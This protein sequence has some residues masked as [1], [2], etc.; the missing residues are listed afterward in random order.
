MSITV[1]AVILAGGLGTRLRSVVGDRPKPMATIRGRPFLEILVENLAREGLR[2]FIL[3]VGHGREQIMGYYHGRTDAEFV[4][5]EEESPLGTG[6]AVRQATAFVR[7][8]PFLL[9]NGDS[10]CAVDYA[11][12]LAFHEDN[13]AALSI[14]VAALHGRADGGTIDLAADRRIV[15]FREKTPVLSGEQAY[16]NAGVYLLRRDLPG[17]WRQTVPFSLEHDVFPGLIVAERCYGFPVDSE[18][19]DIGTPERYADAQSRLKGR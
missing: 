5:A 9:L 17:S 19:V 18:V 13:K 12:F 11:R 16:I 1:D 2:R 8:D 15:R 14:V 7:S 3:C 10:F 4:F 6:G